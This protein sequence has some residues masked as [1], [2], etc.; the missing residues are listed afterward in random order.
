MNLRAIA[1]L[2]FTV[3]ELAHTTAAAQTAAAF[4]LD[5]TARLT[6]RAAVNRRFIARSLES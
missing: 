2:M 6:K 3:V 1:A 5:K 4:V